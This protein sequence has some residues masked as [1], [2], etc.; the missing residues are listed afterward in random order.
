MPSTYAHYRLG[1]EVRQKLAGRQR[2]VVEAWPEL[3]CIGL[4]GPDILFYYGPLSSNRVNAV[5]HELH[6]RSGRCF[7]ENA[8]R[9][10]R[11]SRKPQAA[12]AYAYGAL[13]HFALDV[14]CHPY[15]DEKIAASGVTHTRIEVEFDRSL[16][17]SDGL[18]PVAHVLTDHIR[19][20]RANAEIVAPF[21]PGV[22]ARQAERALR[23]MI[24]Y[25]QVLLARTDGKRKLLYAAL[26][27]AGKYQQLSGHI[28][29]PQGDPVCADSNAGLLERYGLALDRMPELL[30][31][32][33]RY[34]AGVED[35][36]E[37]F[38]HT[39]D[40]TLPE[41]ERK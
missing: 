2:E 38:D 33:D 13:S 10:V 20:A 19:P 22:T 26:R 16:M 25:N 34:L 14:A 27:A 15:V 6:A 8:R 28:V 21:Y 37:L 35:L 4:H 1:Q 39:F 32:F 12:L 9:V 41:K 11:G 29:D 23:S 24:F 40:G 7:F 36:P 18:N 17:L 3:Y 30:R 31:A 5:G